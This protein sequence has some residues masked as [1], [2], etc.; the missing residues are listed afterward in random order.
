M[1]RLLKDRNQSASNSEILSV[2]FEPIQKFIASSAF[3]E[4]VMVFKYPYMKLF[5]KIIHREKLPEMDQENALIY[6]K[7]TGKIDESQLDKLEAIE[8]KEL[9]IKGEILTATQV[10]F[11]YNGQNL[12]IGYSNGDLLIYNTRTWKKVIELQLKTKIISA[13]FIDAGKTLLVNLENWDVIFIEPTNWKISEMKKVKTANLG[14][15]LVNNDRS[16][17]FLVIDNK[18]ILI[19]DYKTEKE[20][21]RLKAHNSGINMIRLSPDQK[22]LASCGNDSKISLFDVE[23]GELL[24]YLIGHTDEVHSFVFSQNGDFLVSSSEDYSIRLWDTATYKCVKVMQNTPA[25]FAM[26]S[27]PQHLVLGNVE[28]EIMTFRMY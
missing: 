8:N 11:S 10:L 14:E 27:Y 24:S 2:A 5:K 1:L 22:I 6:M 28:G 17:L 19:L 12:I 25:A 16:N 4:P 21:H 15:I 18:R 26:N 20:I 13:R 9:K 7:Q 23:S 3:E